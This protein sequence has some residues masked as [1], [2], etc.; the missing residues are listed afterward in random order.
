[1]KFKSSTL[2]LVFTVFVLLI[3]SSCKN[4]N[5]EPTESIKPNVLL[6]YMDDLRPELGSYGQS[7]IKSPNIDALASNGIQFNEMYCNV[8]VCGASRASMLTGMYPTKN[9]F[10]NYN[11]FVS[12]ETP[13]AVTLPMLFKQNG[14]TTI[15][16]GKVYHHLDDNMQDWDE[17]WRPYAFD[18]NNQGLTPTKHWQTLWRDYQLL[19][20]IKIYKKTGTGPAYEKAEVHDS[21]YI[22][23]LVTQKVIRDLKKLKTSN[24]P[25]FLTA[26]F[27]VNHLPFNAPKKYWD[28]YPEDSIKQPYNNFVAK[29]APIESVSSSGELRQY[30]FIA[31]E[32]QVTDEVAKKL[33]HGYYATVS[34]VDALIGDIMQNLKT[35]EL[36]K[37]TIVVLVADHGYNLQEHAQ[38]AK[39]TSHKTSMQVPFIISTPTIKKGAVSNAL[40]E[41]VDI[42]PTLIELCGLEAPGN[43]LEG[44]TFVPNITNTNLKG[45]DFVFTK[46]A[47]AFTIKTPQYCYTEYINPKDDTFITNMLYDHTTDPDENENVVNKTEYQEITTQ[48][49]TILHAN[50]RNNIIGE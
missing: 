6:L 32:G 34:Y 45:K 7:Q 50:Y 14:Y 46:T 40:L 18:K 13:N 39:F 44:K 43:Q 5:T 42:Y 48:L 21:T 15:S 47:N 12:K 33:I 1:M 2:S 16:N 37:N 27:I 25:F 29:N 49:K 3:F 23:G 24:K 38:W 8:P 4:K 36:D 20:N 17:V 35:L 41:L 26:G 28:L 19:E 9:R 30:A 22:D 31:R 11:T 10:I